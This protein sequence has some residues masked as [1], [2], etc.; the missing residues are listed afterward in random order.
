MSFR[1]LVS[2][3]VLYRRS[4]FLLVRLYFICRVELLVKNICLW[5]AF[6]ISSFWFSTN[7]MNVKILDCTI[8][9]KLCFNDLFVNVRNNFHFSLIL[10]KIYICNLRLNWYLSF[11]R[12][13]VCIEI[14]KIC[15]IHILNYFRLSRHYKFLC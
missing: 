6:S 3:E 15:F 1:R 4:R 2:K 7:W 12:L 10:V 9:L 11:S 5:V 14:T 8:R 13:V